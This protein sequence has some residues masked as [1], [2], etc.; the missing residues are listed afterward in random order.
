M[1][2]Y[3]DDFIQSV[4]ISHSFSEHTADAYARDIQQFLDYLDEN[5]F[6]DFSQVDQ[7][8]AYN[9]IEALHQL[10]GD[11]A[12]ST[13]NRKVS[14]LRSYF[15]YLVKNS[16]APYNPFKTIKNLKVSRT[17]P[18]FLTFEE[19]DRL[20]QS[21]DTSTPL[22]IRNQL[23]FE[24]LYG[25]GLRVSELVSLRIQDI[26]LRQR[27]LSIIG[28]GDKERI[29]PFY[30]GLDER[31]NQYIHGARHDIAPSASTQTFFINKFGKPLSA[32]SVQYLCETQGSIANL[33][34]Q[35]HPHVLRH[36]FATHL[37]DN[38][39]DLRV[40]Q[41]LLGHASLSTTQ[42]YTHVSLQRLSDAY[43]KALGDFVVH[44]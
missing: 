19:V 14:T 10:N 15:N 3:L 31:M 26:D 16:Y 30:Q 43:N 17:L 9:Y 28:K 11:Y 27:V 38:G 7:D 5:H 42:V 33:K 40:V 1:R 22:G 18:S 4:R 37:L 39:A 29:V 32:R 41:E 12:N 25:C 35:L 36:T 24:I 21:V 8:V 6:E 44:Q 34:I 23:V 20:I 2:S 13:I